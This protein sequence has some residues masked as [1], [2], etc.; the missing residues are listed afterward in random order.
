MAEALDIELVGD[1]VVDDPAKLE[2][3]RELVVSEVGDISL[4]TELLKA[5]SALSELPSSVIEALTSFLSSSEAGNLQDV[6]EKTEVVTKLYSAAPTAFRSAI[7]MDP[8]SRDLAALAHRQSIVEEFR[9]LLSNEEAFAARQATQSRR[10]PEGV[11][12]A[13]LEANPWILGVG[14]TGQL[15]TAWD[16]A[17]LEQV[18]AGQSVG[19]PGKR[20]DALLRTAGRIRSLVLAEIKHHRT[21]L[22]GEEYR[23]GCWSP[24][25]EVSGGVA[26]IQRTVQL[27]VSQISDRLPEKD[28]TGAETGEATWLIRPRS[29]F[30]AGGLDEL[31]G[32]RGV[33]TAKFESFELYRRNLYEPEILTFDELLARAEWHV[34]LAEAER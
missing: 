21:P 24:S 13:F 1:W 31:R 26:Q 17:R 3:L 8:S 23:A 22:L 25:S 34:E 4:L 6:I 12:Q 18:V 27:A 9:L 33:H 7:R 2:Q 14:L 19:G 11:W 15:L 30:I 10:G 5:A 29:F 16:G 28:D 20:V 32:D